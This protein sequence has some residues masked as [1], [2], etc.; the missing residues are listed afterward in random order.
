MPYGRFPHVKTG[1][2]TSMPAPPGI[3]WASSI[4]RTG[5][6][7][8]S[9]PAS[10]FDQKEV[11][12]HPATGAPLLGLALPDWQ[13]ACAL[14]LRGAAAFPGFRVHHWDIALTDHGPVALEMNFD[15]AL[16]L[17]QHASRRG[18]Y[19]GLLEEALK[20]RGWE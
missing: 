19:A 1:S 5:A 20:R 18:I 11:D 13:D 6:S 8:A 4:L 12:H 9:S 2:T 3:C 16:D 14:A 7:C 17:Y 15:G 10:G